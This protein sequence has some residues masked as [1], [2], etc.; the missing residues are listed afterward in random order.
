MFVVKS[1]CTRS[2]QKQEPSYFIQTALILSSK[3]SNFNKPVDLNKNSITFIL[4]S[5]IGKCYILMSKLKIILKIK[6]SLFATR[7]Y[8]FSSVGA[9]DITSLAFVA[10]W[11]LWKWKTNIITPKHSICFVKIKSIFIHRLWCW[12]LGG[13]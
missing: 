5:D 11:T 9:P 1:L 2:I 13:F 7:I 12:F 10:S 6:G 4:K 8:T 3:L